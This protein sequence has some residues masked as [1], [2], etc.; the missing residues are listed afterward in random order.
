MTLV[1][2]S[3]ESDQL[4]GGISSRYGG[5]AWADT[6]RTSPRTSLSVHN[7]RTGDPTESIAEMQEGH[8]TFSLVTV[9]SV[10]VFLSGVDRLAFRE[11][12][13]ARLGVEIQDDRGI[14]FTSVR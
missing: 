2:V 10:P 7:Q 4:M 6:T 12:R 5:P 8:A 3:C 1:R 9:V 14:C 13:Y 11:E